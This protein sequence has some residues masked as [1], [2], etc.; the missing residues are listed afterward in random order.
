MTATSAATKA[1][2]T[3]QGGSSPTRH[4]NAVRLV[5]RVSGV[6]EERELPSGDRVVTFRLVVERAEAGAGT[7]SAD[8]SGTMRA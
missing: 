7:R 1:E 3:G 2:P 6:P 5:G 4:C 8:R